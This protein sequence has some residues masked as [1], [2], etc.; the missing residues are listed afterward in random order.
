M[1]IQHFAVIFKLQ[2]QNWLMWQYHKLS[3]SAGVKLEFNG[4]TL[5]G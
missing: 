2:L 1:R 4:D 3:L 5:S